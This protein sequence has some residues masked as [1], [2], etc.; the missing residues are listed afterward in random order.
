MLRL[1][2]YI[3]S[4]LKSVLLGG[5]AAIVGIADLA[6]AQTAPGPEAR[7]FQLIE[8][9]DRYGA[10]RSEHSDGARNMTRISAYIDCERGD[11]Q[12]GIQ[13]MEK[14]LKQKKFSVPPA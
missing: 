7:C 10:G 8:Y 11:Y 14:L 13:T 2:W 4:S 5:A 9:Y 3:N 1:T 12:A 6:A